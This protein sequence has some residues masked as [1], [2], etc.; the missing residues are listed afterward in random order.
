MHMFHLENIFF[1]W[2]T[3]QPA[4]TSDRQVERSGT[5]EKLDER[6]TNAAAAAASFSSLVFSSKSRDRNPDTYV[7]SYD[8]RLAAC[9]LQDRNAFTPPPVW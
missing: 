1:L 9:S 4:E 3:S 2:P 8:Q 5:E 7:H 6:Q